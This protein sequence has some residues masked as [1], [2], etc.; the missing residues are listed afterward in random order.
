MWIDR[1]KKHNVNVKLDDYENE[2][3][4]DY[5]KES[6][7]SKSE[8]FRNA[9]WTIR[10]LYDSNLKLKDA[11]KEIDPEKP[12]CEI[13]LP[14]PVISNKINLEFQLWQQITEK[15]NNV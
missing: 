7:K 3:L 1:K 9:L 2:L 11:V 4:K 10:I 8:I 5:Q 6:G 14:I 13:L 15:E 12:L